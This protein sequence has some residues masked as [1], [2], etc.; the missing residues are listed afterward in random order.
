MSD[1]GL[2]G[3]KLIG[4]AEVIDG[5]RCVRLEY[6]VAYKRIAGRPRNTVHLVVIEAA[7]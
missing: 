6:V 3:A 2:D 1:R 7:S 4:T 5:I